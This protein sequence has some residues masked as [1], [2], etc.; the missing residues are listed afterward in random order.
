MDLSDQQSWHF[1]EAVI[2]LRRSRTSA[3]TQQAG[4]HGKRLSVL[5]GAAAMTVIRAH[6]THLAADVPTSAMES[7]APP[8]V[9]ALEAL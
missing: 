1:G 4:S 6:D 9:G 3:A 2:P 5:T 8:E 7:W